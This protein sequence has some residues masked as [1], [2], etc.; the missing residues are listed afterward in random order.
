MYEYS[1][2]LERCSPNNGTV[3]YKCQQWNSAERIVPVRIASFEFPCEFVLDC[4][5][6]IVDAQKVK[7]RATATA[8]VPNAQT[9][10]ATV[11]QPP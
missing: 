5:G 2:I 6:A 1:I 7:G 11:P 4:W 9:R 8:G 10:P 3:D